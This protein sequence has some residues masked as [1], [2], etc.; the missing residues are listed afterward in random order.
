[1]RVLGCS[2]RLLLSQ[3]SPINPKLKMR[4][5]F[6][7]YRLFLYLNPFHSLPLLSSGDQE[8][9]PDSCLYVTLAGPSLTP[10]LCLSLSLYSPL[11]LLRTLST[12][13]AYPKHSP[14]WGLSI[15]AVLGRCTH[16]ASTLS[17]SA[18]PQWLLCLASSISPKQYNQCHNG[19]RSASAHYKGT[20]GPLCIRSL[21][22][23]TLL[24]MSTESQWVSS[25]GR[26][27]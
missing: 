3:N 13:P 7:H 1:M 4:W 2:C 17:P 14:Y 11:Y 9:S 27:V 23:I 24:S 21:H 8:Q 22:Y 20:Y 12:P 6:P 25:I 5:E 19:A 18:H 26:Y 16:R 15:L 10:P